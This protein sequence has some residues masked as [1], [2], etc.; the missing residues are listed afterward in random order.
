MELLI[1]PVAAVGLTEAVEVVEFTEPVALTVA[2]EADAET[3]VAAVEV[4]EADDAAHAA[5]VSPLT[6]PQ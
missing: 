4:V 2:M 1:K 3:P 6:A 5:A